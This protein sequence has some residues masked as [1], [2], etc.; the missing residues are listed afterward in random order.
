MYVSGIMFNYVE[1][2]AL[3]ERILGIADVVRCLKWCILRPMIKESRLNMKCISI[4]H[5]FFAMRRLVGTF[6]N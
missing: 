2:C 5:Y 4:D 6:F 1:F 3:D